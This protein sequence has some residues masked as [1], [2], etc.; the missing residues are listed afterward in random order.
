MIVVLE[1]WGP[2]NAHDIIFSLAS[3]VW[4][5]VFRDWVT[6]SASRLGPKGLEFRNLSLL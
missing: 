1:Q 3:A 5:S 6:A 4:G 2:S